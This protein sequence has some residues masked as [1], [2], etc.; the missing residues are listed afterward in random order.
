MFTS[1]PSRQWMSRCRIKTAH[2]QIVWKACRIMLPSCVNSRSPLPI[3]AHLRSIPAS[4]LQHHKFKEAQDNLLRGMPSVECA[5]GQIGQARTHHAWGCSKCTKHNDERSCCWELQ[6]CAS[7]PADSM[8][9]A[10]KTRDV[11]CDRIL[12]QTVWCD[13]SAGREEE[14]SSFQEPWQLPQKTHQSD[15]WDSSDEVRCQKLGIKRIRRSPMP[16]SWNQRRAET[17]VQQDW[18]TSGHPFLERLVLHIDRKGGQRHRCRSTPTA[19]G[20]GLRAHACGRDPRST[21]PRRVLEAVRL[22]GSGSSRGKRNF[23]ASYQKRLLMHQVQMTCST[24]RGSA[25]ESVVS[26]SWRIWNCSCVE[27]TR[28][29]WNLHSN[30]EFLSAVNEI[31]DDVECIQST[32]DVRPLGLKNCDRAVCAVRNH[33]LSASVAKQTC[34]CQRSFV[35]GRILLQNIPDLDVET[36]KHGRLDRAKE[37]TLIGAAFPSVAISSIWTVLRTMLLPVGVLQLNQ[38]IYHMN[39]TSTLG[40]HLTYRTRWNDGFFLLNTIVILQDSHFVYG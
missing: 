35:S 18:C 17:S 33:T 14:K 10:V 2:E 13:P 16:K 40:K 25:V 32:F 34:E 30:T 26:R 5:S 22:L 29:G 20:K 23:P 39:D 1:M 36:R 6:H 21:T 28:S 38:S 3:T 37:K 4:I 27:A 8:A 19:M 24:L 12:T 15:E 9:R 31:G 7:H 11:R